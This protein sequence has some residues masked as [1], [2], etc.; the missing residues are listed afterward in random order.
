M[1]GSLARARV[2]AHWP[3]KNLIIE[4]IHVAVKMTL[5]CAG[6][7]HD[8]MSAWFFENETKVMALE[9]ENLANTVRIARNQNIHLVS[10]GNPEKLL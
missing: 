7:I 10:L 6:D 5:D 2:G 1:E 8:V 9:R 3:L 4:K